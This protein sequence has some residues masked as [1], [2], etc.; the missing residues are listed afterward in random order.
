MLT[1][2]SKVIITDNT[3]WK[4]WKIIRVKKWSN[5]RYAEVWDVVVLTVK[6]ASVWWQV[7][8]WDVVW[9]VVVRTKRNIKRKDWTVVRFEDNAVALI[10]KDWTPRWKRVFW[11]VAREVREKWFRSLA[12]L[13]EEII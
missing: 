7:K 12:N 9:W 5:A 2:E 13:A 4:I 11:P 6:K 3:W 10:N 8:P 1:N